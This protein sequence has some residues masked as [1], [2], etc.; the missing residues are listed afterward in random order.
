MKNTKT[1]LLVIDCQKYF[2]DPAS[3]AYLPASKRLLPRVKK[4]VTLAQVR[5]WPVVFT[6]HGPSYSPGNLMLAKW[7]HLPKGKQCE[8][9]QDLNVP[10]KA[11]IIHKQH[12]SAFIGTG[13]EKYLKKRG[14]GRVV[15]CGAMTHLCVD[16]TARHAF[17]LGFQ[18]V[19]VR[20]ACC[21]KSPA[22]HRA[23]L[24]A[25][26]HGFAEVVSTREITGNFLSADVVL[27]ESKHYAD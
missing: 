4:L 16:T 7:R 5:K 19:I 12:Y 1:V 25:L 24:L 11:K 6:I 8:L 2:F 27:S 3:P 23:A 13:L 18:P 21:S 17:M 26:G 14:I 15:L 22:L 20:D 10:G 9:Q